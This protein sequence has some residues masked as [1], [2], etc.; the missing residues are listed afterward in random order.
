MKHH[1]P[2]I[3]CDHTSAVW[4]EPPEQTERGE[5]HTFE[6]FTRLSTLTRERHREPTIWVSWRTSTKR[7]P[8]PS[9]ERDPNA[10]PLKI[11]AWCIA[12]QTTCAAIPLMPTPLLRACTPSR[13]LSH[14]HRLLPHVPRL[15][16]TNMSTDQLLCYCRFSVVLMPMESSQW[17]TS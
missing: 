10:I 12:A 14:L 4:L 5:Q 15:P 8:P 17:N 2:H 11:K 9:P 1:R 6:H 3:G 13:T 7:P 16:H